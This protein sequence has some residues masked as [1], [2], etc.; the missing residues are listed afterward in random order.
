M[1]DRLIIYHAGCWDGRVAA[2]AVRR[3][4]DWHDADLWYAQ[5][6]DSPPDV[7]AYEHVAVVDFSYDVDTLVGWADELESLTVLDHHKT[8]ADDLRRARRLLHGEEVAHHI[9]Y[10]DERS[11]ARMAW[12][13]FVD[14]NPPALVQYVEDRDLWRWVLPHSREVVAWIRSYDV[15]EVD[16]EQLDWMAE[17]LLDR[18]SEIERAGRAILRHIDSVVAA[19]VSHSE[20]V[21]DG[22]YTVARCNCC[23]YQSEIGHALLERYGDE[24]DYAEIWWRRDGGTVHSLRSDDD[25]LDVGE[26]ASSLGGGG[27]RN[28]AGWREGE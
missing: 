2:W 25:H 14:D 5:Y 23:V 13:H 16:R 4:P 28:A 19:A 24:V 26:L 22:E 18:R 10:D 9:E 11:G 6:G 12:E 1:T 20:V 8:R 3:H 7:S 15:T 27:H 21:E 17:L